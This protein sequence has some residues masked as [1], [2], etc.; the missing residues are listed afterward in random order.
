MRAKYVISGDGSVPVAV[1]MFGC[2]A[3]MNA[4]GQTAKGLEVS[5][6]PERA[7]YSLRDAPVLLLNVRSAAEGPVTIDLGRNYEGGFAFT[8]TQPVGLTVGLGRQEKT[9]SAGGT[10]LDGKLMVPPHSEVIRSIVLSK[11]FDFSKES[12]YEIHV[13]LTTQIGI[14]GRSVSKATFS[15]VVAFTVTAY[16]VARL[17]E[18][19]KELLERVR[20]S[21][22]YSERVAPATI[23]SFVI[24]PVAVPALQDLTAIDAA[25]A[26]LEI[27]GLQRIGNRAAVE[28]LI[29]EA[30]GPDERVSSTARAAMRTIRQSSHDP[31]VIGAID[32]VQ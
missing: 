25:L 29:D 24:D 28:I 18:R 1:L 22:S 13:T 3:L 27:A 4:Q 16:N 26:D 20:Q 2:L 7:D 8:L 21:D 10:F 30:L 23:L 11:W 14:G 6:E 9:G 32:A 19:C 31:Q 12:H 15:G 17:E 5:F